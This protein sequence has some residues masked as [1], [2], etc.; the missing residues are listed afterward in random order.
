[1]GINCGKLRSNQGDNMKKTE[2]RPRFAGKA[3]F[4]R[5]EL[6]GSLG[7]F[8]ATMLLS[9]AAALTE[10]IN[11]RI[12]SCVIDY[13]I[14]NEVLPEN[15]IESFFI[16]SFGGTEYIGK[17]IYIPALAVIGVGLLSAGIKYLSGASNSAGAE[18]FVKRLRNTLYA[19]TDKL[20]MAWHQKNPAG[21]MIQRCT[22]DVE[23]VKN[24]VSAQLTS[25]VRIILL[26]VLSMF[27]M[28]KINVRLT[29]I[30]A[31][32]IPIIVGYS[33][34]FHS[35]I[36]KTFM[37]ADNEEGVVSSIVQENLTGIRVVRAFGKEAYECDRFITKN[38]NYTMLWVRIMRILSIFW[39]MGDFISGLQVML[40]VILGAVLCVK[41]DITAGNY[42]AFV[43]YNAM[44][45]WPV[46][47]L[48][49]TIADLSRAGVS[50]DRIMYIMNS[51]P[52][53]L[54]AG[55][56]EFKEESYA[57]ISFEKVSFSYKDGTD[58]LT[59]IDLEVKKG[60]KIGIIGGTGS[61]KSTLTDLLTRLCDEDRVRGV[62]KF[63]GRD[64]REYSLT[65]YRRRFSKVQQEPFLFSGT[66]AE[67][68]GI[69]CENISREQI[70]SAARDAA[71]DGII[72]TFTN[73]LDTYVGERG[74]TL[75]GGQKQRCA[76]A[77][78]LV[79][80]A[81]VLIL[82]DSFSALDAETDERIRKTLY[83]KY[84]GMT[85]IIIAHRITT[86]AGCDRIYVLD[87]GRVTDHGTH[88]ELILR[89][90]I[91][92]D[93]YELQSGRQI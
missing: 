84:S 28:L 47:E 41:D 25:F 91:Y 21:D 3:S 66:I 50:I 79:K 30:A 58:V 69:S 65:D 64:I 80:N 55:S 17:H 1:M 42:I 14:G 71:L 49:R 2:N 11:P 37:K 63:M 74:V 10:L 82:D 13:V 89:K 45:T 43:S 77:A 46:R 31:G 68:I 81:D 72:D 76:I 18:K 67:N 61:G 51:V 53:E 87:K 19:H 23:T 40:V 57:L 88:Q 86:I 27:F 70:D 15:G 36:G 33:L 73:G 24:F 9:A 59:D 26:I 90:G 39:S 48:G 44:L 6:K 78:G 8:V 35:R 34:F 12:I 7:F 54:D 83:E 22:S 62:I 5:Y 56:K 60:E 75:S 85:M 32:F 93:I 52:E 20:P 29:L 38:E 92:R 16:R 4:L